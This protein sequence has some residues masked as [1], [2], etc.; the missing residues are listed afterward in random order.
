[1]NRAGAHEGSK[2][3]K[4]L[5]SSSEEKRKGLVVVH[6]PGGQWCTKMFGK[7]IAAE[8]LNS[9]ERHW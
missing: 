1:M 7:I 8:T 4:M 5:G 6:N 2:E 3:L 9:K